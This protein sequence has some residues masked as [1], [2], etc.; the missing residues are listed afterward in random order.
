MYTNEQTPRLKSAASRRDSS[1]LVF[2]GTFSRIWWETKHSWSPHPFGK[3]TG[4]LPLLLWL[5]DMPFDLLPWGLGYQARPVGGA[6]TGYRDRQQPRQ[7][8]I[9]RISGGRQEWIRAGR[10]SSERS[11]LPVLQ[12]SRAAMHVLAPLPAH[13][14]LNPS[15]PCLSI[16]AQRFRSI[17][18]FPSYESHMARVSWPLN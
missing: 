10:P 4:W 12:P 7:R 11:P 13:G 17:S 15:A 16:W 8:S 6:F 9:Q 18:R 3:P 1:T 2:K 5:T 14:G